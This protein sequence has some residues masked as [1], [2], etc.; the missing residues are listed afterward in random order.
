M[1][2][3]STETYLVS[4]ELNPETNTEIISTE[5]FAKADLQMPQIDLSILIPCLNEE[6]NVVGAIE[7]ASA[8]AKKVGLKYEIIVMD[9]GS[10]DRTAEVVRD[11][12]ATHPDELVKLQVNKKNR[13][14][15]R[16]YNDG[17]FLAKG[18]YYRICCG[19]NVEPEDTLFKIFSE[20][21]KA[22]I[23]APFQ[24]DYAG[25]TFGRKVLSFTYTRLI[26]FFSGHPLRYYNGCPM[27]KRELVM[28][29]HS[30]SDGFGFQ[31]DMITRMLDEGATFV[32]FPVYAHDRAQG[33]SKALTVRN[34]SSTGH[35]LLDIIIRRA[36]R[37]LFAKFYR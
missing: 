2:S 12:I 7:T 17:A 14:L 16:C 28:R 6:G 1:L 3:H 25:R 36:R 33:A 11:Y 31:A 34:L 5:K 35:V 21:D 22:D 24:P 26:N 13:G 8:A 23:V 15:A 29:W 37:K 32:E 4:A 19:D 10:T 9:D 20:I 18:R 30:Y 27:I